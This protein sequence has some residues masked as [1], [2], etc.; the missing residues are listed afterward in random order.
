MQR[1]KL[2]ASAAIGFLL[3]VVHSLE[4][5]AGP[6]TMRAM[7]RA[8][9]SL[10]KTYSRVVTGLDRRL[11]RGAGRYDLF[12]FLDSLGTQ[13]DLSSSIMIRGPLGEAVAWIGEDAELCEAPAVEGSWIATGRQGSYLKR[14]GWVGELNVVVVLPVSAVASVDTVL[15]ITSSLFASGF[16]FQPDEGRGTNIA[17]GILGAVLILL[18]TEQFRTERRRFAALLIIGGRAAFLLSRPDGELFSVGLFASDCP[19]LDSPGDILL[20]SITVLLLC[21]LFTV[22]KRKYRGFREVW[23]GLWLAGSSLALSYGVVALPA[24]V[25]G[26]S[27]FPALPIGELLLKHGVLALLVSF[28]E[29]SCPASSTVFCS[30]SVPNWVFKVVSK[31]TEPNKASNVPFDTAQRDSLAQIT[32]DRTSRPATNI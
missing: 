26:R 3:V 4:L 15:P 6:A 16:L 20:S 23:S 21:L 7:N 22:G 28:E 29:A 5:G 17:L 13:A 11:I 19:L 9:L 12:S 25:A 30:R 24:F 8:D 10:N 27:T 18:L 1:G 14:A 31:K 2:A 32:E